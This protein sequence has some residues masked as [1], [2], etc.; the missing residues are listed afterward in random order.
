MFRFT[1]REFFALM[2]I[3]GLACMLANFLAPRDAVAGIIVCVVLVLFGTGSFAVG[4]F[5]G[6]RGLATNDP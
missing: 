5:L 6:R 3:A 1:I 2:S 4:V